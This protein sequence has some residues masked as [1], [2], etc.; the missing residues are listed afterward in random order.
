EGVFGKGGEAGREGRSGLDLEDGWETRALAAMTLAVVG[1]AGPARE[2]ID[3]LNAERPLGTLVQNYWLPAIR[4]Q[5]ELGA[6]N[7]SRAIQ[8]LRVAEPYELADTRVP[9]LPAYTR[10]EAYLQARDGRSAQA[11]FQKLLQH[12]GLVGNC[13]LGALAHVGL[14]RALTLAGVIAS[15]RKE[16]E[17][18]FRLWTG[19]DS[20]IPVLMQANEEYRAIK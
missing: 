17:S 16:Y 11:E 19:A 13:A 8:L 7:A 1:D 14:A 2:L 5:L 3:K 4:A 20:N 9:L 6:G 12:R 18:L 10:G 15:A